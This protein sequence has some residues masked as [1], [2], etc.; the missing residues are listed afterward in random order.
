MI[1]AQS[2]KQTSEQCPLPFGGFFS[3]SLWSLLQNDGRFKSHSIIQSFS[4]SIII[5]FKHSRIVLTEN[6]SASVWLQPTG[7]GCEILA[8]LQKELKVES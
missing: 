6:S 7:L 8:K 5:S 2:R 1:L 4:H 3:R